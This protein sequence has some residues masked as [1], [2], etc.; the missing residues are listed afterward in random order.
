MFSQISEV[1]CKLLVKGTYSSCAV[2]FLLIRYQS[3]FARNVR[4]EFRK[5]KLAHHTMGEAQV[6]LAPPEEYLRKKARDAQFSKRVK[7]ARAHS[8][9]K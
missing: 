8:K 2:S 9:S 3:Q 6:Q 1:V 7:S 5:G 4:D